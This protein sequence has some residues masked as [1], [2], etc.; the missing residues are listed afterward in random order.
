MGI[1]HKRWVRIYVL[2]IVYI[3]REQIR[4]WDRNILVLLVRTAARSVN[5]LC[6]M[7][8][9]VICCKIERRYNDKPVMEDKKINK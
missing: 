7:Q 4:T 1:I 3:D 8:I 6:A 9:R 2:N 5:S